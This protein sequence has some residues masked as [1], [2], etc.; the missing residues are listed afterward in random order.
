VEAKAELRRFL[1]RLGRDANQGEVG[2]I[3]EGEYFGITEF[4]DD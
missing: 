3:V 4:G 2:I 1:H